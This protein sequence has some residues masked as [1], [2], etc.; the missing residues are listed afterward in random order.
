MPRARP[1]KFWNGPRTSR[2]GI[3]H[4]KKAKKAAETAATAE[5]EDGLHRSAARLELTEEE[6]ADPALQPYIQKAGAKADKL[7]AARAAL[8]KK[9][10]PVKEKV[11]DAASGKAKST[12][13]FEQQDK[14]PPSLKPNP[15]SRPLSEALLF[16]HGKIHEVEH[17]NVG[18][19]GGHK[20]E[21]LVDG[22][23]RSAARLELT[24][25]ERADPAL[26]PYIHKAEA[27]ADKLD[28]ARAAL[29]KKRVPVKEKVYDA[30]SGKAK[31]TLRFEQQDKGPPSLK[32][33]PA[34]RPLSEALLFAHG[35]IHEVEHEN[36]GVEGG[37][38]GEELVE[39]QTAKVIRSGI[40]HHKMKPYKAVEK[41]ERQLMSANAEYF[42]QK[43]LRDNPQ[44]AQAA[45]N[46]IS[47]MW[48]K[49]RIKQQYAKAARQAGQAAAQGA[50]ATA[51]NGFRVTKLAA[52][53]GERVAEFAARNWKTILIVAVFGLLALLLITGLQSCTVMAGTAGTGVTASSYFSK[54]K[55]ML[56]AEKAYAKLEQKLQRYL[57]TYEATHNYD[58]YHFYLDEI[59]H[60]PYVLISIL[61]ALH[62]GVFTLAEVQGELEMLF[63]KQYI[64]T[65]TVTMQ[66]RYRTKMMVIIGPYGVP[67][68]ITYQEPYEYYI[69]TVKLK[70]KDLSH[71]PVEV[72]TEEQL[73]AYSLYMR[74]LGNRP[75]LFGKA[76]YPNASTIKQPTYY[77][78]PPEALKDDKFA[79][80]MEEATKYIGYPYVWGGSSPS[81]SFDC[82]G[83]ISWVLNHSGWNVG[84]QTAQGLYNLCT[85]VSTAQVKPGD[86][87][88][89]KG[90]YDTPGVSHCGIYVG[91]SI[92]LHCGDP[93]SYTNL[94]SK[95]WQEH[96]YSYGRLP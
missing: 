63:E 54:D 33:N 75:D 51:E 59:E 7:D 88:F 83:Y 86:L 96:F 53:G 57:D 89:F 85:P 22:L 35:K 11:Y 94:N 70:N 52:E 6:R 55:D 24:E 5:S 76:Q 13:R 50:A 25:E 41:A 91:N 9:R 72:L 26:Q 38:K 14:G 3:K 95:Y 34:S 39:H 90:T 37:H 58:E 64:L 87:V 31:S 28:A 49:R 56:G 69:C 30:A 21:E 42:Y 19:E 46:P 43:S 79:A 93:I 16:A 44:I 92:M 67:Q 36:V 66:I 10:V 1:K 17:E 74:T 27:K 29:P 40:R 65:E 73:S 81:T 45:S 18:V 80:M 84:R 12:L 68:V 47:R 15:A 62:D 8:P 60:D 48:Q 71:L 82:S 77:D 32:P 78:I 20:G 2:T 4:K 61:S 23:H